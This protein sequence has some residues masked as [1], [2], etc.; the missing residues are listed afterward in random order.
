MALPFF[1]VNPLF[2][3]VFAEPLVAEHG[4]RSFTDFYRQSPNH[5][6]PSP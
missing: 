1:L 2:L 4:R 5:P 3:Y 6:T